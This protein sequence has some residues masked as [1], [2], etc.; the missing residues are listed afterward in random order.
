MQTLYRLTH[1]VWP[2]ADPI[3]VEGLWNGILG[4]LKDDS[5]SSSG[6]YHPSVL[7]LSPS[8]KCLS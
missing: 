2:S 7:K 5:V 4:M 3:A 1:G 8:L 6:D